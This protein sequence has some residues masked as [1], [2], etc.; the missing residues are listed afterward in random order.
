MSMTIRFQLLTSPTPVIMGQ[1]VAIGE[2]SGKWKGVG[3]CQVLYP[4]NNN[5]VRNLA[6]SSADHHDC[7]GLGSR[8]S[9]LV[10]LP[11]WQLSAV[12]INRLHSDFML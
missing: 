10:I 5:V 6:I 11:M 3:Q 4:R 12:L 7:S 8:L 2:E 1:M 9:W